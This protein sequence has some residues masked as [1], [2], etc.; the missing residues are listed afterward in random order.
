MPRHGFAYA[1]LSV[2]DLDTEIQFYQT[3]LDL[4][5]AHRGLVGEVRTAI[6]RSPSGLG[7]ELIQRPGSAAPT[8]ATAYE[9]A[10]QQGLT[11]VAVSTDDLEASV[12][13]MLRAGGSIVSAPAP[14]LR[15]GFR[16]AYIK[17]PE[18]HLIEVLQQISHAA[19]E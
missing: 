14:A 6:L 2:A 16:F 1:G 15:P 7:I 17:D 12:A 3:S 9:A 18:G 13:L 5:V 8:A 19:P 4:H 11:H 10:A